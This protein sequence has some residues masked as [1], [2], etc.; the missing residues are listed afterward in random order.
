MTLGV[1][2]QDAKGVMT[3]LMTVG[4]SHFCERHH[5][6]HQAVMTPYRLK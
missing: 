2:A 1:S 4:G 5:E 3:V 6:C